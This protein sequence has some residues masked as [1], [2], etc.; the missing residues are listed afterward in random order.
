MKS[1]EYM[2]SVRHLV[3]VLDA[4]K[5]ELQHDDIRALNKVKNW[6]RWLDD[7]PF[8]AKKMHVSTNNKQD[9]GIAI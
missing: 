8:S 7:K 1:K 3:G 2:P 4:K 6:L 5:S 9:R